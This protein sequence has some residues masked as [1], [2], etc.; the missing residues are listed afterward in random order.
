MDE[1]SLDS[2]TCNLDIEECINAMG[3]FE[4]E[5]KE[6][7]TRA[8]DKECIPTLQE[9]TDTDTENFDDDPAS[10]DVN[11]SVEPSESEIGETLPDTEAPNSQGLDFTFYFHSNLF[12]LSFC[13]R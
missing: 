6:G 11:S 2:H 4:C 12:Q 3:S 9:D 8:D 7:Y 10:K 13:S 5:C 1:C